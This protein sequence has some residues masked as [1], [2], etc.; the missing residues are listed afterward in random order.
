MKSLSSFWLALALVFAPVL[1]YSNALNVT[2]LSV[3][4]TNGTVTFTLQW[5]NSWRVSTVPFNWD[6]AWV[7]VKFR[8]CGVAPTTSWTHGL[9]STTLGQHTYP[10]AIQPV[11]S[12][13]SGSGIDAAPNNTGVM[14]RQSAVGLYPTA[15]P[16]T[17]TLQLTNL[18]AAGTEID[19]KVFG[20]EMVF[21][22]QGAYSLGDGSGSA[23]YRFTQQNITGE[24][25]V[26]VFPNGTSTA[27]PAN[28]P[29]GFAA[30][31]IMKYE[32]SQGQYAEFLNTINSNAQTARYY[33]NLG[34]FRF[35][36]SNAGAP[37]Q[38]FSA[39]RPDRACNFLRWDDVAGYLDWACLRPMT[40]MEYEK[41]CRGEAAP[42]PDEFAWGNTATPNA[43][44]ISFTTPSEN[45]TEIILNAGANMVYNNT[46]F[47]GGDGGQGPARVG[48]FA[49]PTTATR[50][51]AG[52]TYYG[53]LEMSGNVA[54]AVV[55]VSANAST[56]TRVWGDG[57]LSAAG[58]HD[59]AT[60]PAPGTQNTGAG[61]NRFVG[62]RGGSWY[63]AATYHPRV[64]DRYYVFQNFDATTSARYTGGRGVR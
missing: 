1:A 28:Y 40:E 45:G 26:N 10:G 15:G 44:Q 57:N 64:S 12:D 6:A 60:W 53:V 11:L 25:A 29:K 55:P 7:F 18:P 27:L 56:Y 46:T 32:I 20:I 17:I 31:H 35:T 13:G 8:E 49:L 50:A 39:A 33:N 48:I 9:V 24:G 63:D 43:Q 30:F 38:I 37:P 16:Y 61:G 58:T 34:S 22:P 23:Y 62:H 5:S 36:I 3:N 42:I 41:A 2:N 14:F 47:S 54:E 51:E 52:A 59:A 4:Q 21:I 19:V